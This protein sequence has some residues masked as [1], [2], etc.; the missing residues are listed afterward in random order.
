DAVILLREGD[1]WL[2]AG[3]EGPMAGE[4]GARQPLSPPTAPGRAMLDGLTTHFPDTAAP[5][6]VEFAAAH[7][8]GRRHGFKAALVAPMLR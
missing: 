3:H 7:E 8:F 1:Q 5:D 4:V 6:P 2:I